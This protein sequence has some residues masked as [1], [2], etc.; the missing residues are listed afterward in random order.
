MSEW[1]LHNLYIYSYLYTLNKKIAIKNYFNNFH[2][3]IDKE[4]S[5]KISPYY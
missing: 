4:H 1:S 5:V 2:A 3:I